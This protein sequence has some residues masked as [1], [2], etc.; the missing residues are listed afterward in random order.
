MAFIKT[1]PT[2]PP[3]ETELAVPNNRNGNA[4]WLTKPDIT[5]CI[6][7]GLSAH[8]LSINE[9]PDSIEINLGR[10]MLHK[11]KEAIVISQAA[12]AILQYQT[13]P[14]ISF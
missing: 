10:Q 1:V 2:S 13:N 4:K 3:I 11:L 6:K 12:M 7:P 14:I 5:F 8:Y 9:M